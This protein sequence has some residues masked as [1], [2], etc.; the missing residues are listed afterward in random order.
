MPNVRNARLGSGQG[1]GQALGAAGSGTRR[2]QDREEWRSHPAL[3]SSGCLDMDVVFWGCADSTRWASLSEG[4]GHSGQETHQVYHCCS[5]AQSCPTLCD[6]MDCSTPGFPVLHHLLELAQS[7]VHWV[8][9]AFQPSRPLSP[10][11]PSVFSLSQ[12]QIHG[13][14]IHFRSKNSVPGVFL[15]RGCVENE[16]VWFLLT[17][18]WRYGDVLE[19]W[20]GWR[21]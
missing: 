1:R 18:P 13:F 4:P 8:G 12:H 14:P 10:P 15:C 21:A 5:V 9:D 16:R 20:D 7:H 19:G 2:T 3:R 6:P 17:S 11:S